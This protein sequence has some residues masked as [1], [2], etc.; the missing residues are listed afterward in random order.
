VEDDAYIVLRYERLLRSA[1]AGV[2]RHGRRQGADLDHVDGSRSHRNETLVGSENL[3][4]D[5]EARLVEM[6]RDNVEHRIAKLRKSRHTGTADDM[7]ADLDAAGD[8]FKML[9]E[10]TGLPWDTKQ[11]KPYTEGLLSFSHEWFE[12]DPGA[13]KTEKIDA[14]R[15]FAM[16]YLEKTFGNDLIHARMDMDERTPHVHFVVL[17]E[18][19][20]LTGKRMLGHHRHRHFSRKEIAP[21]IFD[22]EEPDAKKVRRSYELIQSE[23]AEFAKA[24]GLGVERGAKRAE[25]NRMLEDLGGA[26]ERRDHVTPAE[27]CRNGKRMQAEAAEAR[28][29]AQS[30][31]DAAAKERAA[32][33]RDHAEAAQEWAKAAEDTAAVRAMR[34]GLVTEIDA[35]LDEHL[36]HDPAAGGNGL[37]WGRRKPKDKGLRDRLMTAVAPAREVIAMVAKRLADVIRRERAVEVRE[38]ALAERQGAIEATE[39]EQRRRAAVLLRAQ[40]EADRPCDPVLAAI[41]G[42]GP[43]PAGAEAFPGAW[44]LARE[45]DRKEIGKVLDEASNGD[46]RARWGATRDAV[47]ILE[48]A[49]DRTS[50]RSDMQRGQQVLENEAARRGLDLESGEHDPGRATDPSRARLHTDQRDLRL[51]VMRRDRAQVRTRA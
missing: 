23:V 24:R 17:P 33:K 32:A 2:E 45:A 26:V 35:V 7:A 28:S 40:E 11:E 5:V 49:S 4:A 51:R 50:L 39:A 16:D 9:E 48:G 21:A 25:R 41:A 12:G 47:L 46:L 1:L 43:L 27:G 3:C 14:F 18:Y 38:G 44:P 29:A 19:Q 42:E 6:M 22:D 31:R 30:D 15:S 20:K 36:A 37:G 10:L 34:D 13:W 8:D